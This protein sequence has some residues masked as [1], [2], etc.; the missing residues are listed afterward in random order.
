MKHYEIESFL[1][2]EFGAQTI[3]SAADRFI[4]A[5]YDR[6]IDVSAFFPLPEYASLSVRI[7]S[8]QEWSEM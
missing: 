6:E 5:L 1:I 2:G 3:L 8:N 7:S 4:G